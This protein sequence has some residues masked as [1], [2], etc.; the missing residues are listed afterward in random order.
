MEGKEGKMKK[1][2]LVLLMG[3]FCLIPAMY[4]SAAMQS[5]DSM[6]LDWKAQKVWVDKGD[7]CVRGTFTNKRDDLS[8]TK[9]NDF[10]IRIN[11]TREDGTQYQFIGKAQKIPMVKLA[12]G[13]SRTV[14]MNFGPFDGEWKS[15]V[16]TEDYVFTYIYGS[17]W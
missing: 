8:I 1:W 5:S 11:F 12:A 2:I 9:L 7:L 10:T 3:L 6:I 16:S 4:S 15:W 13:K 14:T 17:R